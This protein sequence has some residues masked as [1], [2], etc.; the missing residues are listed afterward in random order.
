MTTEKRKGSTEMNEPSAPTVRLTGGVELPRLGLG[1]WPMSGD[2]AERAVRS[3][4]EHGYRS[5][6]TAAAYGNEK[7]VG[8]AIASS[9]LPREDVVVTTKLGNSEHGYGTA[10]RACDRSLDELGLDHIDL[11]LIHWPM[12][13]VNKYVETWRALIDLREQGRVRAIGV[14]NFKPA[15]IDRLVAETGVTP[16][17]NQIELNPYTNRPAE[18]E[19]HRAQGIVTESWSPLGPRTDLLREP[20]VTELAEKHGKQPG[21]VVLRWHM[22]LGLVATP[23]S[24]DAQRIA[25]NIDVF[26]FSLS[27][28][29]VTAI[30]ALD[31]GLR[32]PVDSDKPIGAPPAGIRTTT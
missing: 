8:R 9:G 13:S 16:A 26:D 3:A 22:D 15:H 10:L 20:V 29:E 27:A 17:V 24:S 14:S 11:Y 2:K 7:A 4:L 28:D 30:T 23:K 12:P 21:Q 32:T 6:D 5:I 25:A 18:R 19:Y 1:T 31:T